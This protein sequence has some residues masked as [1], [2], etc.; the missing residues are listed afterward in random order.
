MTQDQRELLVSLDS[1]QWRAFVALAT[2]I[3]RR[4]EEKVLKC[5]ITEGTRAILIAKANADGARVLID[6]IERAKRE[7]TKEQD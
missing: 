1:A 5:N 6:G 7:L 4:Q 3:L 2:D